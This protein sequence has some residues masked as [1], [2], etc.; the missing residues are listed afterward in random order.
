MVSRCYASHAVVSLIV[1]LGMKE[2][3]EGIPNDDGRNNNIAGHNSDKTS[4]IDSLPEE[5]LIQ[6][7]Q[8]NVIVGAVIRNERDSWLGPGEPE[9]SS[10]KRI[11]DVWRTLRN[12]MLTCRRWRDAAL[13][14]P[15]LWREVP[16]GDGASRKATEVILKRSGQAPIRLNATFKRVF[17]AEMLVA[18]LP[19]VTH[20]RLRLYHTR[21]VKGAADMS[22]LQTV[23]V[24]GSGVGA[25]DLS[26]PLILQSSPLPNFTS[27][28]GADVSFGSISPLLRPTLKNL[29]LNPGKWPIVDFINALGGLPL[30]ER[31]AVQ[32]IGSPNPNNDAD[33]LPDVALPHLRTLHLGD[34]DPGI[35]DLFSHLSFPDQVVTSYQFTFVLWFSQF[36]ETIRF[37]SLI[38]QRISEVTDDAFTMAMESGGGLKINLGGQSASMAE[39]ILSVDLLHSRKAHRIFTSC[40]ADD[41]FVIGQILQEICAKTSWRLKSRVHQ[42]EISSLKRGDHSHSELF[43]TSFGFH[44]LHQL[45]LED[46]PGIWTH[47]AQAHRVARAPFPDPTPVSSVELPFPKLQRLLLFGAVFRRPPPDDP[48]YDVE[49]NEEDFIWLL[50]DMVKIRQAHGIPLAFLSI[51]RGVGFGVEDADMLRQYVTERVKWDGRML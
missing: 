32:F 37:L 44:N 49:P 48:E 43:T 24:R 34:S 4:A 35:L 10:V 38:L 51:Y 9:F 29:S 41:N 20:L 19:R 7:F 30:L 40:C 14:A 3:L 45:S 36:E 16:F 27:L 6:I 50:R 23:T 2:G 25:P 8:H 39:A 1:P 33:R 46:A 15:I 22:A 42:L 31:L 21:T 12:Y 17:D 47:L 26:L 18:H 11:R 5:L 28:H 13:Q